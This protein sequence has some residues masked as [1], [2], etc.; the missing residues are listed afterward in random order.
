MS[1]LSSPLLKIER[2]ATEMAMAACLLKDSNKDL[3]ISSF[4]FSHAIWV[5]VPVADPP[6]LA[7]APQGA[8]STSWS[9]SLAFS[10]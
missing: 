3:S 8:V 2:I 9:Q 1:V 5:D 4:D 10:G 7:L 6:G